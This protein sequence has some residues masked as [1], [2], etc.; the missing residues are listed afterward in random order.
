MGN[1]EAK[2]TKEFS[3]KLGQYQRV[4]DF[5]DYRFGQGQHWVDKQSAEA[6]KKNKNDTHAN[7]HVLV[8]EKWAHSTFCLTHRPA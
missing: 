4:G 6:Q 3:D 7:E 8:K 1:A 5:Q 2:L